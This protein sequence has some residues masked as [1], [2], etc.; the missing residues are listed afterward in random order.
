MSTR[1]RS[2]P[3]SRR[4]LIRHV[5]C[6]R[7]LC[8]APDHAHDRISVLSVRSGAAKKRDAASDHLV[9][10][11]PPS[12]LDVSI[13][14]L[15][16]AWAD[17]A[18]AGVG[19]PLLGEALVKLEEAAQAQAPR[20]LSEARVAQLLA[21]PVDK[22]DTGAV[23]AA[24]VEAVET[25]AAKEVLSR[26]ETALSEAAKAQL[27]RDAATTSV[28][29]LSAPRTPEM[30][31]LASLR[32]V[33]PAASSAGVPAQIL[34][35]A[36]AALEEGEAANSTAGADRFEAHSLRLKAARKRTASRV[37]KRQAAAAEALAAAEKRE[38]SAVEASAA[39]A[40]A[41]HA[42]R[43][44]ATARVSELLEGYAKILASDLGTGEEAARFSGA[45]EM[46]AAAL[47]AALDTQGALAEL[48]T[49]R[50]AEADAKW[51]A[52]KAREE[53][54]FAKQMAEV[55]ASSETKQKA[56]DEASG[57]GANGQRSGV[58][59]T[60]SGFLPATSNPAPPPVAPP[61][62]A[63]K[64]GGGCC[65][66]GTDAVDPS[67]LQ[68]QE[69]NAPPP[70]LTPAR[71]NENL[72]L[73]VD[74]IAWGPLS[75]PSG[76]THQIEL[77]LA[78]ALE[79]LYADSAIAEAVASAVCQQD[80]N[81][82]TSGAFV[83]K[84]AEG[85][86][87][88]S[89]VLTAGGVPKAATASRGKRGSVVGNVARAARG[90][91]TAAFGRGLVPSDAAGGDDGVSAWPGRVVAVQ[92]TPDAVKALLECWLV[93]MARAGGK[94]GGSKSGGSMA[95]AS[96]G[97]VA[98]GGTESGGAGVGGGALSST[99]T[100]L[101]RPP[102]AALLATVGLRYAPI[103]KAMLE[104]HYEVTALHDASV[105]DELV[106]TAEEDEVAATAAAA[107]L[108]D[109]NCCIELLLG[110]PALSELLPVWTTTTANG[111]TVDP[112][113]A[114][115]GTALAFSAR[116][117]AHESKYQPTA[118]ASQTDVAAAAE[119]A[120]YER[121]VL[122]LV[123]LFV[124]SPDRLTG[125]Q[126]IVPRVFDVYLALG[127]ALR[128]KLCEMLLAAGREATLV[129]RIKT[130]DELVRQPCE[131]ARQQDDRTLPSCRL[132]LSHPHTHSRPLL[133]SHLRAFHP[134]P[135]LSRRLS[136]VFWTGS[137]MKL[138]G[139]H[140]DLKDPARL[141]KLLTSALSQQPSIV[142]AFLV[143]CI[144]QA[145][146]DPKEIA[147]L[148]PLVGTCL[149]A[150]LVHVQQAGGV[151]SVKRGVL[152]IVE[153]VLVLSSEHHSVY[154][155]ALNSW[156]ESEQSAALL[157][158]FTAGLKT[159]LDVGLSQAALRRASNGDSPSRNEAILHSLVC[160]FTVEPAK[161]GA[162]A[163]LCPNI[164]ATHL[165]LGSPMRARFNKILLANAFAP[166]L[167]GLIAA[168]DE[169][170][171]APFFWNAQVVDGHRTRDLLSSNWL[172]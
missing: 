4:A 18:S 65:G 41:T 45:E 129:A 34:E 108:A 116:L 5:F 2:H 172:L 11:L 154:S 38:A 95:S 92:I 8:C 115:A 151:G 42:A 153:T 7:S 169:I 171:T 162:F 132:F 165:T 3:C 111:A 17:A 66:G 156:K 106:S 143:D 135:S 64:Q 137:G 54:Y 29:A 1:G 48:Q 68:L 25:G 127:T 96:G 160:L 52:A 60:G 33:L 102:H 23:R 98:G 24:W 6:A 125:F 148:A 157:D 100:K 120:H 22:V 63:Q 31:D 27:L 91:I 67:D 85:F 104:R 79:G 80:P 59:V 144:S 37:P 142:S 76:S 138:F 136:A 16:T 28:L 70:V 49:V 82:T 105:A 107:A 57:D 55:V 141:S 122:A 71:R 10:L 77:L 75:L 43:A 20:L 114:L 90:S 32:S 86:A 118:S 87:R 131:H 97:A 93:R 140:P 150:L 58:F 88:G 84:L 130:D 126:Q 147:Q 78:F 109:V 53:A 163:A 170:V 117:L 15:R 14:A 99:M 103:L 47:A 73:L 145:G 61:P 110:S 46:R 36:A 83:L 51:A 113:A 13:P 112:P 159:R 101:L 119:D 89:S 128:T 146:S 152:N 166:R 44:A 50:L 40:E 26:I 69:G 9:Q 139:R 155:A 21:L 72:P 35:L 94:G 81:C 30:A 158:H 149:Q 62:V 164:F 12:A 167:E 56:I 161:W 123:T 124:E 121:V 74:E 133:S 39:A 168:N 19:A 134:F